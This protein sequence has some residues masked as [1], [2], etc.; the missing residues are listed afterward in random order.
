MY[1]VLILTNFLIVLC[2]VYK[3]NADMSFVDLWNVDKRVVYNIKLEIDQK[4][5]M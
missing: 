2:T 5:I 4:F 1:Q 3:E